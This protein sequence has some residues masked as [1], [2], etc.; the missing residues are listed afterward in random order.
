MNVHG[1]A[2]IERAAGVAFIARLSIFTGIFTVDRFRQYTGTG[3]FA[4][5]ARSA[6]KKCVGKLLV[7]Y[8]V[9]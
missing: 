9:L 1:G 2:F 6:K 4:Y 8:S 5:T 7:L 3:G